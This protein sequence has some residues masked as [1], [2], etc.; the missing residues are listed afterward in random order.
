MNDD[1]LGRLCRRYAIAPDYEDIW[2]A[3]RRVSAQSRRALLVA[4]GVPATTDEDMAQALLA[5]EEADWRHDLPPVQVV[6]EDAFPLSLEVTFD[7][8]RMDHRHRWSVVEEGGRQHQ[9]EFT[10]A[11]LKRGERRRLARGER[12]RCQLSLDLRPGWGYHR[13]ELLDLQ[14][15][16]ASPASLSLIV[17]PRVCYQP[18]AIR[19]GGRVW[20][21]SLQLYALRS[22]RNWGM[23]DFT[24]LMRALEFA[25]AQGAGLLGVNPLHA[26]FPH[27]PAHAS[28]YSPSSRLFLNVLYLDVEAMADFTECDEARTQVSDE[29]FQ[30]RLRALRAT[31]GVDYAAVAEAKMAV[32]EVLYRHFRRHH[33]DVDSDR[34]KDFRRFQREQGEALRRHALFEALQAWL[35]E[36]DPDLWGWQSWPE[37]YARPDTEAVAAFAAEYGGRVEFYVYL[38]WQAQGQLEAVGRRAYE[39]G[40]GVGLYQDLAVSVDGGGAEAWANQDLY[41][42]QAD[43]GSPPDDFNLMGQNWGLPPWCPERLRQQAYAPFIAVL[44]RNMGIAGALRIDHV[45]ALMRLFWLPK[46]EPAAAGAY[47][48]YPFEDLLGILALESQRNQCL[49]IGEDLGTVPVEVR[50][51]LGPMGVLCCRLLYHEKAD[52]GSFKAPADVERQAVV[53]VTS[54]DLPTLAGYWLGRDLELRERLGLFPSAAQREQQVI[55]RAEDRARLLMALEGERL[56]PAGMSVQP[57]ALPEM[58]LE[59][60]VG[61]H[62]YLARTPAQVMLIQMEDVLGQLEQVNLPGTTTRQYPNWSHKLGLDLELWLDEPGVLALMEALRDER[63]SAVSP[64]MMP[65]LPARVSPAVIPRATYR[66]QLHH[67]FTFDDAAAIVPY[68]QQLGISH[69][70]VSSCMQARPGSSH[71][72]DIIDHHRV[73]AELGGEEAFLRFSDSLRA[74][75]MGLILDIVP[76]HMGVMGRD[77]AWWLDVLENGP[78]S[79]YAD[80]FDIN[81][82]PLKES[83]RGKVLVPVLGDY[84]GNVLEGGEL[85]LVFDA[86]A[87]AFC[88]RYYEHD[89]PIDPRQYPRILAHDISR[90]VERLEENQRQLSEFQTLITAFG[91][92]PPRSATAV[93]AADRARDKEV[94]KAALARLYDHADIARFIDEN[95]QS[96]ND[97]SGVNLLHE[98]LEQQ[99]W[100]LAYWRVASDEINYRR[101]FDINELAGLCMEHPAVF[102]TTHR[103]VLDWVAQGRIQGLRV[104]HPDGLYQPSEYFNRLQARVSAP[105]SAVASGDPA[106]AEVTPATMAIR[107]LYL[108][109]EKILAGHERLRQNWAVHGTTGYDFANL[110]NGLFVDAAAEEKMGRI[111][112]EFVV[113]RMSLSDQV[114]LCKKLI[115]RT[116]LASELNVLAQLLSEIAELDHHTRDFTLNSLREAL[117]EIVAWFPVYRTYVTADGADKED[118]RY[119]DWAVK[120]AKKHSAAADTS[121]F[122]FLREV[123]LLD[124]AEGKAEDYR[125][126]VTAFAMKFQQ[127]TGP[128][129]AKGLEDTAFYRCNRLVSLNEVGG[130]A[131][132]FGVSVAAFHHQNLER[133][134]HWP[135]AMLNTSTH[136]SKRSEDVR[137]RINVLS[138]LPDQWRLHVRRWARLNRKRK[139]MLDDRLVPSRNDEYLLYQTLIGAWP[140]TEPDEAGWAAF[141]ERMEHYMLKAVKE[142]KQHT[143]WI[144]PDTDYEEAMSSFVAALLVDGQRNPFLVDFLAL[145]NTLSRAGLFN[146]LSQT[147]LKFTAPGVPDLYQGN[148]S[149]D[150]SLVDPD[151][152]RPVDYG[153]RR[154]LLG[155]IQAAVEGG[156]SLTSFLHEIVHGLEDGRAKLYLTWR[157]LQWRREL[158]ELFRDGDY[159]PLTVGGEKADHLCAYARCHRQRIIVTVVPRLVYRLAEG[160]DPLGEDIWRE[161]W[162]EVPVPLWHDGLSGESLEA[163]AGE[164]GWRLAAGRVLRHFPVAL[165]CGEEV[166]A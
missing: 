139:R 30:A 113:D 82:Q 148:E 85:S 116:A 109:A 45:M 126:R 84:Y 38:Q 56:L 164:E 124:I 13:F 150:L 36:G 122:G 31:E 57:V 20:G 86:A 156:E 144:N 94:H 97:R 47:V 161:T 145:Q 134:H 63:G 121:V 79:V 120:V 51:A 1:L 70:Y 44:R 32:L 39:L 130:E 96:F 54:H 95:L 34:A 165:L 49:V 157:C 15:E 46:G 28:P 18:Q 100:R 5:V 90:L 153:Q 16:G 37:P 146:A 27:E 9:G 17:A 99:A 23:G 129:M 115:M 26:L 135:Q 119:V 92:L 64:P 149:W 140:L 151:N 29:V 80:Y 152:R 6:W 141:R 118:R 72:Y 43:M 12:Q 69:C 22:N 142:A 76:N 41:A 61:I 50:E 87:G 128:V 123:L 106:S 89:F 114:Y 125:R 35:R 24:D 107:S 88:L 143:S 68:L 78:A 131:E 102:E 147:L 154:Q 60:S 91:N 7:V 14:Q 98:L 93:Q 3:R 112:D 163:R 8:N 81:W 132:R 155:Q 77:N 67:A 136:D 58:P 4:M 117:S 160:A 138:E 66:L 62:R 75:D 111:Y 159:L 25:A 158:A 52:D 33:L 11:E 166:T 127:Y 137:A 40:L 53:S 2:G 103:L 110:V 59:L 101:F 108:V 104:D 42:L 83:L 74:H 162:I 19:D 48:S 10:P 73:N 71:G 133:V 55:T 65:P 21:P 105:V